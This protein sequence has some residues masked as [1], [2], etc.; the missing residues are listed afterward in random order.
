VIKNAPT[1]ESNFVFAT[2]MPLAN[3]HL[4][5]SQQSNENVVTSQM[6][7]GAVSKNCDTAH[8]PDKRI[9][10]PINAR[11]SSIDTSVVGMLL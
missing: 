7:K 2:L 9:S 10:S 3:I 11:A 1:F 5:A 8:T 4:N 6:K